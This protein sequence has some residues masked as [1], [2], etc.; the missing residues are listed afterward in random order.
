MSK[1]PSLTARQVVRALKRAG[2]VE[3]RQKGSHLILIQSATKARTV[4]PIHR[5]KTLKEPLL[6]GILRDA[7][8]STD[9]FIELL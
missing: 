8:L 9:E 5:G 3:D 2:F 7:N 4:V 1:L 6:R